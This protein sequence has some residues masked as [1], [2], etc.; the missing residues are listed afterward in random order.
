MKIGTNHD[1]T[2]KK[3]KRWKLDV[4][5]LQWTYIKGVNATCPG[6]YPTQIGSPEASTYLPSARHSV[7]TWIGSTN[8]MLYMFG[9]DEIA[10]NGAEG[11]CADL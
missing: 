3:N 10:S 6:N 8:R 2:K 4:V 11:L 1:A 9:G 7:T 5:T